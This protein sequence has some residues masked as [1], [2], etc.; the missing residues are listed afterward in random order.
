MPRF[1]SGRSEEA[2][3]DEGHTRRE[4]EK[5]NLSNVYPYQR[6]REGA[7]RGLERLRLSSEAWS[8]K[9]CTRPAARRQLV[10][11]LYEHCVCTH[12]PIAMA[13]CLDGLS[14]VW[15]VVW[16]TAFVGVSPAVSCYPETWSRSVG[17]KS[18]NFDVVRT[19]VSRSS[20][21]YR[22]T[23]Y[24]ANNIPCLSFST[25]PKLPRTHLKVSRPNS[26]LTLTSLP[27]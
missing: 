12:L 27:A 21:R 16:V 23:T 10:L 26:T 13:L 18:C 17:H 7:A 20:Y 4:R 11:M 3:Q 8:L 6:P 25:P 14:L 15:A 1:R 9:A 19:A 2:K 22:Y 5:K 24:N